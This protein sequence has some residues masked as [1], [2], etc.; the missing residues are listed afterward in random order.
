MIILDEE[1]ARLLNAKAMAEHQTPSEFVASM[2]HRELTAA[3]LP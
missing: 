3:G 2:L 1:I